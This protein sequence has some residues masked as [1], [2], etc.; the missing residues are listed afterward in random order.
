MS[1]STFISTLANEIDIMDLIEKEIYS[2]YADALYYKLTVRGVQTNLEYDLVIASIMREADPMD[3][4]TSVSVPESIQAL[5]LRLR[6]VRTVNDRPWFVFEQSCGEN[7]SRKNRF[8]YEL[9]PRSYGVD[10]SHED[11]YMDLVIFPRELILLPSWYE[12]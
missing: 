1:E 2:A 11:L 3:F 5:T 7:L 8:N 12:F 6:E 10:L 4:L 9:D